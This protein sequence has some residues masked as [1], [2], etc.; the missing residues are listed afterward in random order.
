[1]DAH[2]LTEARPAGGA[3]PMAAQPPTFLESLL[4]A[5]LLIQTGVRG[6]YG[7]SA[8]FEGIADGLNAAFTRIGADQNAEVLRFPPAIGKEDFETSEYLKS[9]PQLA[10]TIHSFCG[11]DRGHRQL[12]ARLEDKQ[13]WTDQ[14]QFTGV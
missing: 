2:T 4:A 5:G 12:L 11:D 6:L 9:F 8:V 3:D 1:M 10:G 13:D 7:R 14:Q